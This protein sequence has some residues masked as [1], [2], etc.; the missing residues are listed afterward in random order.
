[1]KKYKVSETDIYFINRT[2]GRVSAACG[3]MD[4]DLSKIID[5]LE[6]PRL[7]KVKREKILNKLRSLR[8]KDI[9]LMKARLEDA[10]RYQN[11]YATMTPKER[12][13]KYS[14]TM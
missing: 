9:P 11:K 12:R 2:I 1:M 4:Y 10:H 8:N 14:N 13:E 6:K 7:V 5:E 3:S